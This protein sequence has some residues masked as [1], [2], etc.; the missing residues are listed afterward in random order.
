MILEIRDVL[1]LFAVFAI[2]LALAAGE[3]RRP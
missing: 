1:G 2:I 3:D